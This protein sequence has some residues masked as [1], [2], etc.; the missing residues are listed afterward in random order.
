MADK[1]SFILY[2]DIRKPLELLTDEQRG[3]LFTAILDYSE[4]G[5]EPDFFGDG[6]AAMAFAFIRTTLDANAEKY[7]QIK[8]KRIEAGSKGGKQKVANQANATFAKQNKQDL[9]N[10]AVNV[11]V[12]GNDILQDNKPLASDLTIG[13]EEAYGTV[14]LPTELIDKGADSEKLETVEKPVEKSDLDAGWDFQ[15]IQQLTEIRFG[16][17]LDRDPTKADVMEVSRHAFINKK[18][19]EKLI[20]VPE[21]DKLGLLEYALTAAKKAKKPGDWAYVQGTLNRL[22]AQGIRSPDQLP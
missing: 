20:R 3:R 16:P 1:K 12:N 2:H 11:N 13:R 19:G 5:Q 21:V 15:R 7:D 14:K 8:A 22:S 10:Q 4:Y 6:M 17:L 18:A 9:A